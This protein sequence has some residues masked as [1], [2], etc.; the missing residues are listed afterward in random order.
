MCHS[1]LVEWGSSEWIMRCGRQEC[2]GG[3]QW[4]IAHARVL[5]GTYTS[6]G[7]LRVGGCECVWGVDVLCVG[8]CVMGGM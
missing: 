6:C 8:M 4:T 1:A 3:G 5:G 7:G 2:R